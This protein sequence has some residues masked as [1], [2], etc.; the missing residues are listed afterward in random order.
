MP[1]LFRRLLIVLV[2]SIF[3]G[4]FF[5][6]FLFSQKVFASNLST[7][8]SVVVTVCGNNVKESGEQCDGVDLGNATCQSLGYQGGTLSCY[9]NCT[10]NTSKCLTGGGGGGGMPSIPPPTE[11]KVIIQGLAYPGVDVTILKDGQVAVVTKADNLANFKGEITNITA[12]VWTFSLWAEDHKGRRS[13]TFS[14]TVSIQGGMT[15]TVSNIFLPPTID[16][17]TDKVR[18]GELLGILGQ[19][20]PQ[21]EI[22]IYVYSSREPLIKKTKADLVGA[23]FYHLD[24]TPLEIGEHL[25]KVKATNGDGLITDFSKTLTFHVLSAEKKEKKKE[26]KEEIKL[27]AGCHKV[28]LN[29]D[30]NK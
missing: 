26:Q 10:F 5:S 7:S 30:L 21:S 27:P 19:S 9:Q 3:F 24:T 6:P 2:L 15:T 4:L 20:A 29:C 22:T 8:V 14:F 25:T 12:G 1:L 18:Q 16:L 11:T 13:Q 17:T 23:Y 28:N